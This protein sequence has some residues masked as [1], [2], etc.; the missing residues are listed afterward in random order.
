MMPEPI[1]LFVPSFHVEET[2]DEIRERQV[3]G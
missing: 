1:Q 2:L 3:K